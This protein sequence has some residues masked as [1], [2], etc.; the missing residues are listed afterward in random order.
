MQAKELIQALSEHSS[1]CEDRCVDLRTVKF[2]SKDG[3]A[4]LVGDAGTY[5]FKSDPKNPK[6]PEVTHAAKQ[7]CKLIGVPF[8][9]Y[10]KNPDGLRK[11]MVDC[12]LPTL[13]AEKSLVLM[14]LRRT[15]PESTGWIIRAVL[16][17]EFTN[18]SNVEV[19]ERV[20]SAIADAYEIDFVVGEN[21]DA[22]TLHTQF[23]SK[24]T[25]DAFG[26]CY[27][28]GFSVTASELGAR[29]LTI[30]TM[31]CRKSTKTNLLASYGGEPYFSCSYDL[32]Q[33]KD[34][35]TL[36]PQLITRMTEQLPQIREKIQA[37]KEWKFTPERSVEQ[38]LTSL[39]FRRGLS[40]K[41]HVRLGQEIQGQPPKDL[42]ELSGKMSVIAKDF[43]L[44][45]R[46]KIECAAGDLVGLSF[47][48]A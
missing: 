11:Q 14:K 34:L 18:I 25:F 6:D 29:P 41:F 4:M 40:E 2:E 22:L 15:G 47:A 3:E 44:E 30:D 31:L 32:I 45:K 39:R 16:P 5:Y 13:G 35:A 20:S 24:S 10:F 19:L 36:F 26:E 43:D 37:T 38:I 27:S 7:F 42:W 17:A 8:S 1:G 48:K 21:R 33:P 28:L 23:V 9:F 46:L 12:W